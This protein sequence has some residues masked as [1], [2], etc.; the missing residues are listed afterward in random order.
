MAAYDLFP[1]A[2]R[3]GQLSKDL[4]ENLNQ[5]R[6]RHD[7]SFEHYPYDDD[8]GSSRRLGDIWRAKHGTS[9]QPAMVRPVFR[10]IEEELVRC[11]HEA[12][13]VVGCVAWLTSRPI[14]TALQTTQCQFIVQVEDWLRPDCDASTLSEAKA[15]IQ[16]LRPISN[17]WTGW[18]CSLCDDSISP[19]RLSGSPAVKTRNNPRMHHKFALFGQLNA[20]NESDIDEVSFHTV[21]TGSYNWTRNATNSL[22]NGLF[23]KSEDVVQAYRREWFEVLLTSRRVEDEWWGASYGWSGF[24]DES[25]REGT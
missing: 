2:R 6:Y 8:T 5:L 16:S 4:P 14:L 1:P 13:V 20:S 10:N 12:D 15:L 22:E 19:L 23:I 9:F 25:L 18:M 3:V 17:W 11:I 24:V 21:W 7:W